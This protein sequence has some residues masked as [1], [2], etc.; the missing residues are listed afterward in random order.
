MLISIKRFL[1]HCRNP[2]T[3]DED[4]GEAW[5]QMG[6]VLLD[7]MATHAVVGCVADLRDLRRSLK[8]LARRLDQPQSAMGLLD[9]SSDS[10]EALDN[11][12]QRATKYLAEGND[13]LQSMIFMLT[14]TVADLS[15]QTDDS[16][17]R[18]H[19]IE[20]QVEH[21]SNLEDRCALRGALE[22]CLLDLRE[23]AAQQRK[24]STKTV[25][26]L[27]HRLES[28]RN[29]TPNGIKSLN[30]AELDLML[31]AGD[32]P[33][34]AV[35]TSFVAAFK[36]QRSEHIASR[37]GENAKHQMLSL[38]GT[39]LK[40]ALGP[41]DRLLRWKGTSF[42]VF[43]NT[44][45]PAI[46]VRRRLSESVAVI[47]QQYVEVGRSSALL[48]VGVDWMILPPERCQTLEAVFAEVDAFLSNFEKGAPA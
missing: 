10:V 19:A 12:C 1:D 28:A 18:L 8:E 23:A 21:A 36:L 45:D 17:A 5:R 14:E 26:R 16:V 33:A 48:S 20:K 30:G 40:T 31:D 6:H 24:N 15:G 2:T 47:E 43:L 38:I 29:H 34:E 9:I 7:A 35:A 37:F 46:E 11:Y 13:Q 44:T 39:R 32:P 3:G 41:H 27:Q 42:V 25:E 4:L 22:K